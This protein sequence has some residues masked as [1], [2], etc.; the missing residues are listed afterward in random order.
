[1]FVEKWQELLTV[2]RG[3]R[4][5]LQIV[6]FGGSK[7]GDFFFLLRNWTLLSL[8]NFTCVAACYYA[9][10]AL[11]ATSRREIYTLVD[12]YKS[13]YLRARARAP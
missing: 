3:W 9:I 7:G 10:I 5:E 6:Y 4:T 1:M 8:Q 13:R 12:T 2:N 11:P